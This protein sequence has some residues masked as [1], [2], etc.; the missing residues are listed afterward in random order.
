MADHSSKPIENVVVGDRVMAL[1]TLSGNLVAGRVVHLSP[2]VSRNS[3]R[4]LSFDTGDSLIVIETTHDH[5]F[6]VDDEYLSVTAAEDLVVGDAF[7][8]W[9]ADGMVRAIL[10]RSEEIAV[11][12]E[13]F[14]FEVEPYHCYFANDV[15]VH[16]EKI[17]CFAEGTA[18][19]LGTGESRPIEHV[20]A[21]DEVLTIDPH[22]GALIERN[23]IG[24]RV[25]QDRPAVMIVVATDQGW[26]TI[27]AGRTHLF[28]QADL[29][30]PVAAH[31]LASGDQLLM[32]QGDQLI[33]ATVL[34]V[35]AYRERGALY[36]LEIEDSDSYF[37]EGILVRDA[38]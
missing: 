9:A 31:R 11:Q 8:F 14:N 2:V 27:R 36:D 10:R 20:R 22:T 17:N 30:T 26:V 37:A 28:F 12:A 29:D 6:F 15:L 24:V 25:F 35:E 13:V 18:V 38:P 5:P 19:T 1:D 32:R 33:E 21:G 4:A 34:W 7:F 23:V 3:L 16:N